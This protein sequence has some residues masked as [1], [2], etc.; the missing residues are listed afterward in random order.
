MHSLPIIN[1]PH[2]RCMLAII[3]EPTLTHYN[4]LESTVYVRVQCCAL[5]GFEQMF[6]NIY[7]P[8]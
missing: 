4:Y 7:L 6:N 1:S 2:H 3:N 5:Y 8:L